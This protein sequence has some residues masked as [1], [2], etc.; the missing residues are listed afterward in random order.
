MTCICAVVHQDGMT[1]SFGA[2]S[3]GS[4]EYA[5]TVNQSRKIFKKNNLLFGVAGSW[6]QMQL[7]HYSLS[8]PERPIRIT[9]EEYIALYV[10]DAIRSCFQEKNTAKYENNQEFSS[11]AIL[12]GYRGSI[13]RLNEDYGALISTTYDAI[14]SGDDVAKGALYTTGHLHPLDRITVALRSAAEHTAFVRGP[15]VF[16]TLTP[17]PEQF[18]FSSQLQKTLRSALIVKRSDLGEIVERVQRPGERVNGTET[19]S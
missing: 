5:I 6:R 10:V 9:D 1:I 15:F 11:C 13:Y 14:G 4:N 19:A 17:E 2:D 18:D 16:E 12:I 3:A 7:L 8:I